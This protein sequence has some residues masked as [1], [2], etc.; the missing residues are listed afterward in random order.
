[1]ITLEEST[2]LAI[3][4]GFSGYGEQNG[5]Y[6]IPVSAFHDRVNRLCNQLRDDV[7]AEVVTNDLVGETTIKKY[8]IAES[9]N[10]AEISYRAKRFEFDV[11]FKNGKRYR[12]FDFPH[13]LFKRAF[14]SVA[15]GAF[16]SKEVKGNYRY[17]CVNGD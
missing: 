14:A 4:H 5:F 1:M 15:I 17:A 10:V 2:E 7:L 11:E 16:L 6:H 3:R 12:Y 8:T 9:V 13:D